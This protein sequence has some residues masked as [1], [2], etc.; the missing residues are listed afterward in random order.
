VA[1]QSKSK[2]PQVD[3][4]SEADYQGW[5][6][7]PVTKMFMKYVSD[8]RGD[9]VKQTVE[10]WEKRALNLTDEME[11]RGRAL[12]LREITELP[13]EAILRFY[14]VEEPSDAAQEDSGS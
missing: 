7:H 1:D 10:A 3:G 2:Q 6:H 13:F 4:F 9:L 5:R 8:Y 14:D 12:T 11:L